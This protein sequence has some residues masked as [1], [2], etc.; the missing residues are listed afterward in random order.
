MGQFFNNV[1]TPPL[2]VNAAKLSLAKVQ[3]NSRTAKEYEWFF[4]KKEDRPECGG[5]LFRFESGVLLVYRRKDYFSF[6]T[7]GTVFGLL[8]GFACLRYALGFLKVGGGRSVILAQGVVD[9]ACVV[10]LV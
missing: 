7:V 10:G 9:T 5:P 1:D 6:G 8:Q 4:D 3:S 2:S